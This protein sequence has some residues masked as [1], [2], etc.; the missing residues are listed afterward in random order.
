MTLH[1]FF[2]YLIIN[3]PCCRLLFLPLLHLHTPPSC[4]PRRACWLCILRLCGRPGTAVTLTL[5]LC[6]SDSRWPLEHND[7]LTASVLTVEPGNGG[8]Q[9][10]GQSKREEWKIQICVQICVCC[11]WHR[12]RSR[13]RIFNPTD[14]QHTTQIHFVRCVWRPSGSRRWTQLFCTILRIPL[15]VFVHCFG[16]TSES[17][18]LSRPVRLYL[19]LTGALQEQQIKIKQR[20]YFLLAIEILFSYFLIFFLSTCNNCLQRHKQN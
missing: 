13:R 10:Q 1:L 17:T 3:F 20:L 12:R 2:N 14:T 18:L 4:L 9:R 7:F 5:A 8:G 19:F 16:N 6:V 11:A 15:G